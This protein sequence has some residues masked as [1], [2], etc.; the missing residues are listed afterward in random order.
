MADKVLIYMVKSIE[1]LTVSNAEVWVQSLAV[2][3][4]CVEHGTKSA[5]FQSNQLNYQYQ[6]RT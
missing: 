3:I 4:Y 5:L 2:S 1:L 6:E